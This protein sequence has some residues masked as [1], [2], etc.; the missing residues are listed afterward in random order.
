MKAETRYLDLFVDY[1]FKRMFGTESSKLFLIDFLN[2]IL[3]LKDKI[4]ELTY[5]DRE[6]LGLTAD[7]RKAVFDVFCIDQAGRRFI[8][9]L[10]QLFQQFFRD[11]SLYYSTFPIQVQAVKGEWSYELHETIT[12][13]ILKF[14]FDDTHPDQLIHRVKL[15]EEE[16][17]Q[18]FNKNL[19][20]VYIETPKFN[21]KEEELNTRLDQ[22]LFVLTGM[23]TFEEI[24]VTLKEDELFKQFFM[25]AEVA[26][27][28]L[29]EYMEYVASQKEQWDRYAEE[30]S[31]EH[32]G[33]ARGEELGIE[34][35]I[36]K[37]AK[38]MKANGAATDFISKTTG[39]SEEDIKNLF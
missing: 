38:A 24:P 36:L 3:E 29:A 39:L 15:I 26:N 33:E 13:G 32:R 23:S 7:D 28:K 8:I 22:W 12:I 25:E 31:A 11:R 17:G 14:N 1:A 30:T 9:E 19:V 6:Q 37:V 21:K 18:V 4:V 5:L 10:Q 34:K 20:Y 16:S 27:L 2:A 35:G